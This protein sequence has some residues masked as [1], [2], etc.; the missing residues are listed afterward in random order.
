MKDYVLSQPTILASILQPFLDDLK[1]EIITSKETAVVDAKKATTSVHSTEDNKVND[2]HVFTLEEGDLENKIIHRDQLHDHPHDHVHDQ[3]QVHVNDHHHH[4]D[5][6]RDSVENEVFKEMDE[7]IKEERKLSRKFSGIADIL[8]KK[9]EAG[10]LNG[11]R[12]C[13]FYMSNFRN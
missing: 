8:E 6:E 12:K 11:L 4:L 9:M 13:S 7:V 1:N 5:N 2:V 3:V 10:R